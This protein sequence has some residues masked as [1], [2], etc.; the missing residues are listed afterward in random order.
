MT[1]KTIKIFIESNIFQTSHNNYHANKTDVHHF[2]DIWSSNMFYIND[3]GRGKNKYCRYAFVVADN[4][5]KFGLTVAL[6]KNPP[7]IKESLEMFW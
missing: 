2:D 3:Y 5:I 6:H 7:T 1:P 4:I